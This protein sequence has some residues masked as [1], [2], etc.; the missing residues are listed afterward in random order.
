MKSGQSL[1][2]GSLGF[3]VGLLVT[4]SPAQ[5]FKLLPLSRTFTPSGVNS[6]Q[7]YEVENN[8]QEAIAIEVSTVKREMGLQGEDKLIPADQD[9]MIYPPQILLQPGET[10]TVRV[11]WL[12]NSQP[13]QELAYR[14]IAEQLPINLTN[15][16]SNTQSK[17]PQASVK[18]QIRY[19]GSIYIRPA[20]IQ[21]NVVIEK[22]ETRVDAG[23]SMLVV[24]LFNQGK[25]RANLKGA[26]LQLTRTNSSLPPLTLTAQQMGFDQRPTLLAKH[27]RQVILPYPTGLPQAKWSGQLILLNQSR[28]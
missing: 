7:S 18:L 23:K 10:Q 19:L 27:K 9:F 17:Q 14:L 28:Y 15:Q 12:G 6:T 24:S 8:T 11:T 13:D 26:S 20:M 22:I 4:T 1:K 3:L 25:A 16:S 2:L 5:A 21:P